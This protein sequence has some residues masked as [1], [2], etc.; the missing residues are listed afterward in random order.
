MCN[1]VLLTVSRP[2]VMTSALAQ[3][4]VSPLGTIRL[5]SFVT[6]GSGS[7]KEG[8]GGIRVTRW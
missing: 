6:N 8:F 2:N 4:A 3:P 1:M 5:A 7:G